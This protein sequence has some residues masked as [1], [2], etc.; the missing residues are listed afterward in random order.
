M[1][2]RIVVVGSFVVGLTVRVPR[3][4]VLGEAL[5]G[6]LFDIGPG[7]KGTNQAVAAARQGARVD[8]IA[9]VGN[10]IF[11]ELAFD[12]YQ[13]EG[14]AQ[15][16]INRVDGVNTGVGLVTLLPSSENTIVGHL[17]ANMH[18]RPE[19]VDAAEPLIAQ[20]DVVMTQYEA[21]LE[22]VTRALELGQRHGKL[23]IWNPAP[24]KPV[25][26]EIFKYVDVLTPNETETRILLG[27]PPDDPM[28]TTELARQLLDLGVRRVVVTLGSRGS[29]VVTPEG[30]RAV[31]PVSVAALDET[32]AGDSFNATLAICLAEGMDLCA[33][34]GQANCAGAYATMHL[35][36][37]D[38]LPTR[39]ELESFK[40]SVN[41]Q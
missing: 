10:D 31:P 40:R 38:G 25:G 3:M 5:I 22:S 13:R 19:Y 34:A 17:G 39:T 37:V 7:G 12:L 4:P 11:A 30:S 1:A 36:V 32:G 33:A 18:M 8:L 16:H 29:V 35:G 23:T 27:R 15:E 24:A 28:P 6:D 2:P 14:I 9:C 41:C 26:R 21:P 20:S